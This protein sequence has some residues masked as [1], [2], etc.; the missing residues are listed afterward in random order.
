MKILLLGSTG[1]LGTAVE[2]VCQKRNIKCI[3]LAHADL[4]IT[5]KKEIE[6]AIKKYNPS[7]VINAV[8]IVGID[9]CEINPQKA[10]DV[11]TIAVANLAKICAKENI[12][13]VQP[14]THTV[15]DGT[16]DGYYTEEDRPNP[17]NI[18]G[19]SKFAAEYLAKNLCEKYYIVRFSTMF[20]RRRN[21]EEGL[22]LGFVGKVLKWIKEGRVLRIADDKIDSPAYTIDVANTIIDM[23]KEKKPFGIY[24]IANAGKV[25]YY[26]FISKLVEILGSNTKIIRAK[27]RDFACLG[28]KSLKTGMRS[29]KLKALRSW[30]DALYE[31][32]IKEVN[33]QS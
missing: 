14:S 17:L 28:Q 29:I 24:H 13:L 20:G 8:A 10:F 26:D 25:S 19:V 5:N 3:G 23:L 31:Y 18:Y 7:V 22:G 16:K 11:N 33:K 15:F 4:E 27:D 6:E 12:I 32:I 9:P 21:S 2:T 1:M 30:Q